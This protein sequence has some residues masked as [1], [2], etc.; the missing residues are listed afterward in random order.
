MASLDH[1][2]V[3]SNASDSTAGANP[4][5]ANAQNQIE[6]RAGKCRVMR[7]VMLM[8]AFSWALEL[9]GRFADNLNL[10][11]SATRDY[12]GVASM[13]ILGLSF[14]YVLAQVRRLPA[15][16]HRL[17]MLAFFLL[18]LFQLGDI[19][20]EFDALR[21]IPILGKDQ[22]VHRIIENTVAV[23]GS[24]LVV[25][26]LYYALFELEWGRRRLDAEREQLAQNIAV[27]QRVERELQE[28]KERLEAQVFERTAELAERNAQLS[29]ELE[30]RAR[31]EKSLAQRLR[32][33]ESLAGC[34]QA[35]Q[36]ESD[37]H[38]A[39][40]EALEHL[41]IA[42]LTDNVR[43]FEVDAK[44]AVE[45][46]GR[47]IAQTCVRDGSISQEESGELVVQPESLSYLR[48]EFAAGRAVAGPKAGDAIAASILEQFGAKSILL[49]PVVWE[50]RW[51]GFLS[52][53]GGDG[54][55]QWS[56]EEIR[57]LQTAAD[58]MGAFLE[59]H[60]AAEALRRAHDDLERRVA[61]RTADLTLANSRLQQEV[62]DRR[63]A[64]ME[65]EKLEVL[66][67]QAEKMKAIGTLAGGIAHD[68]NN[69]LSSI[70]GF[71]EMALLKSDPDF[72]Y[73]RYLEEVFKAGNRAKELVRQILVFS[74]QSDEERV[75]VNMHEIVDE[76]LALYAPT[77]PENIR[78]QQELDRN[79]GGVLADPVQMH[80]V[81]MN[82]LSNAEH[83]M[84]G[85]GGILDV[86]LESTRVSTTLTTPHGI[87]IPGAYVLLTI[88][89]T[90]HGMLPEILQR[91]YEPFFTTKPVGEGTGMGLSIVHGIVS[92]LGG[93]IIAES[94][95]MN[96]ATF[97][98]YLPRQHRESRR[99]KLDIPD[100]QGGTEH[101]LVVDDEPQ[102][103]GMW[104]EMLRGMGYQ[105]SAYT[106]SP[107]AMREF[108][109]TPA[110]FDLA[111]I[112]QT[113]PQISGAD[114]ARRMLELRPGFPII[115]ATGF[116]ES[117]SP[118][119]AHAMGIRDYIYKPIISK[120][121]FQAIRKAL[122][123]IPGPTA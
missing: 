48:T 109:R 91:I 97:R 55:R 12:L 107:A 29:V 58:M 74:R 92:S 57:L 27:R 95:Y 34:S 38:A 75:P 4:Q 96:G 1:R 93:A 123:D 19:A 67:R 73:R 20:D 13:A 64:E 66:L 59:R 7:R 30:E 16:V 113:M 98:I 65:K 76:A 8:L 45:T 33:E 70:I 61:E 84:R 42:S 94:N 24:L 32:Y 111:L 9:G 106:S 112:D 71:T 102:L 117:V 28:A 44:S 60:H 77:L 120:D 116:S 49:I 36:T 63:K 6:E 3:R 17:L 15:L 83:A 100:T 26:G 50:G 43:L 119:D 37:Q 104:T 87:L 14:V 82:L 68:F 21:D 121:L 89:D 62:A 10:I 103:V 86:R 23:T 105:V 108:E 81:I 79:S 69:I 122:G 72:P 41:R 99:E 118:E 46:H 5:G 31:A 110:K 53:E 101:I 54:K 114:L 18:V 85:A 39:M 115:L 78:V 11:S 56:R 22:L 47:M 52:F 80:Q 40:C 88:A 2:S 35:L 51:R 25:A 90:G